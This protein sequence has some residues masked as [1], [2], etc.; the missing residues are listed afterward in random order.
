[1]NLTQTSMTGKKTSNFANHTLLTESACPTCGAPQVEHEN[2]SDGHRFLGCSRYPNCQTTVDEKGAHI[3]P[4]ELMPLWRLE[5]LFVRAWTARVLKGQDYYSAAM[6]AYPGGKRLPLSTVEL[7][8][9]RRLRTERIQQALVAFGAAN[10][11]EADDIR[12]WL[13][14]FQAPQPDRPS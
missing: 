9:V 1:M 8:L 11:L 2:C 5:R 4:P 10:G 3:V 12:S 13:S 6:S 14:R 7:R